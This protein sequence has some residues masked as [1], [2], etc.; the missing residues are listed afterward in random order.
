MFVFQI[1]VIALCSLS[2][3]QT[4]ITLE[5]IQNLLITESN[6]MSLVFLDNTCYTRDKPNQT[7]EAPQKRCVS[8]PDVQVQYEYY[9][10]TPPFT[11]TE[12]LR[13]NILITEYAP[14]TNIEIT[15][16]YMAIILQTYCGG[17]VGQTLNAVM[18]NCVDN[19][20]YAQAYIRLMNVIESEGI[21]M[22]S[23]LCHVS[24]KIITNK[25]SKRINKLFDT[26]IPI[27]ELIYNKFKLYL[28]S[29]APVLQMR[30]AIN[31]VRVSERGGL[32]ERKEFFKLTCMEFSQ[33][34]GN[35]MGLVSTGVYDDV[36]LL[37]TP[38]MARQELKRILNRTIMYFKEETDARTS[39][40]DVL[41][42]LQN[43]EINRQL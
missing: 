9:S 27:I 3:C 33:R 42:Q 30:D 36:D 28:I 31:V 11:V 20:R 15:E 23:R 7:E 35:M 14:T 17:A 26:I 16:S 21:S 43:E 13:Y 41:Q 4:M 22:L 12:D 2:G 10:V 40:G 6:F 37:E 8:I 32:N 39:G 19:G 38:Q 5:T 34:Y 24:N 29:T 25:V 18:M 1:C